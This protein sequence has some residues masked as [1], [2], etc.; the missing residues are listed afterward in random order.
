M[1]FVP[2]SIPEIIGQSGVR[3][4][5]SM[6]LKT[7][8]ICDT[9]L[10]TIVTMLYITSPAFKSKLRPPSS[11]PKQLYLDHL[12]SWDMGPRRR[13]ALTLGA[14]FWAPGG[15]STAWSGWGSRWPHPLVLP[16]SLHLG[17]VQPQEGRAGLLNQRFSNCTVSRTHLGSRDSESVGL[18]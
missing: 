3:F 11:H 2:A 16:G 17:R 5:R 7:L 14:G 15:Q 10:L 8:Q 9:V 18:G 1:G 4:Q 12:S 13:P 6:F